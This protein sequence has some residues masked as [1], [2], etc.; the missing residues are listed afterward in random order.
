MEFTM[1]AK[2]SLGYCRVA[3]KII[4]GRMQ[5]SEAEAQ[6]FDQEELRHWM[7]IGYTG[8]LRAMVAEVVE[9]RKQWMP[10]LSAEV[11]AEGI[12]S[13]LVRNASVTLH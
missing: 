3:L 4:G 6:G 2:T 13:F 1:K 8:A 12:P 7:D 11:T 10:E 5:F 9:R